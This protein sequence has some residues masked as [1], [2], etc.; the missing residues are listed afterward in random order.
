MNT[1]FAKLLNNCLNRMD[2]TDDDTDK[3]D[4]GRDT[5]SEKVEIFGT[6][7]SP[8]RSEIKDIIEE[9][10]KQKDNIV[11]SPVHEKV[12]SIQLGG[13]DHEVELE[14]AS[15]QA[16]P[17]KAKILFSL[18]D[19]FER[20]KEPENKADNLSSDED[21]ESD[22]ASSDLDKNVDSLYNNEVQSPGDTSDDISDDSDSD[23][24]TAEDSKSDNE[25]D[26]EDTRG[27]DPDHDSE[28]ESELNL[29]EKLKQKL[30]DSITG[31]PTDLDKDDSVLI[32]DKSNKEKVKDVRKV[33]MNVRKEKM[34]YAQRRK[35]KSVKALTLILSKL[36][37]M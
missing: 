36:M 10:I 31:N 7:S 15:G 14:E 19:F 25:S 28:L 12:E 26:I 32:F 35:T 24:D 23:L 27:D 30:N 16:S 18:N 33:M 3:N 34:N 20:S 11:G 9:K 37:M 21:Q 29:L 8:V 5:I 17:E 13:S 2:G 4:D 1:D 6:N 22:N